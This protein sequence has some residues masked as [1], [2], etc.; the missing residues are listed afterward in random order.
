[1]RIIESRLC[2]LVAGITLV[3]SPAFAQVPKPTAPLDSAPRETTPGAEPTAPTQDLSKKLNESNGIIHPKRGG[4]RHREGRARRARSER[5]P[6]A[7]DFGR[8]CCAAAK[9]GVVG[10]WLRAR[11]TAIDCR[12]SEI[13]V[14]FSREQPRSSACRKRR[15]P[16]GRCRRRRSR[17]R[18]I[19]SRKNPCNSLKSLVPD[20]R[21]QGIQGI[22]HP[23]A[24][25]FA[26]KRS[27]SKTIRIDRLRGLIRRREGGRTGSTRRQ[28]E[29]CPPRP[30]GCLS[31]ALDWR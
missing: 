2:L 18:K 3:A 27:R 5:R 8:V 29:P 20:E 19:L 22:H 21:I 28:S 1:M 12:K 14:S 24:V 15:P 16:T 26:A 30:I 10:D 25:V 4:P 11:L 9:I 17:E 23:L 31:P 6:S 13:R 7:W